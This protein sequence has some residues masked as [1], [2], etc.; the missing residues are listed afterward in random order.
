[1]KLQLLPRT[2]RTA[3]FVSRGTPGLVLFFSLPWIYCSAVCAAEP[4]VPQ[5]EQVAALLKT[6]CVKCHGPAKREAG[7]NLAT[8]A[9]VRKGADSGPVVVPHD[10]AASPL[11]ERVAADEMP[12]QEP[13]SSAEKELLKRW[14]EA[15]SPGLPT[16][17]DGGGAAADHWAFRK[18]VS[19]V[20][21]EPRHA[22]P[23][24]NEIDRFLEAVLEE[25]GLSLGP[26]VPRH[27]QLRRAS[28]VL[29]GL[30]PTTQEL[31]A[32]LADQ[33]PDAWKRAIERY[34]SIPQYGERWGKYWL[35]AAG[36]SDS[37]GY[38]N[39]D[40]DRPLAWRYR[41]WVVNAINAD[42]PFDEFVRRQIAGDE[43][44][45]HSSGQPASPET[46]DLLVA[47]HYLRNGQDGTGESDGNPDEV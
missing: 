34:L 37:N 22:P 14:I 19:P 33:A 39:A 23:D 21:P 44:A 30:P 35:D 27:L 12:P 47:T 9:A 45:R 16:K 3:P 41:D 17:L 15:G 5:F 1:M 31:D 38:F 8:A 32:F 40:S 18:L 46:I 2:I 26:E 43:I 4:A 36:Y 6:H 13:L 7:L 11:W 29:T 42:L 24:F 25:K 20:V 28:F 10:L